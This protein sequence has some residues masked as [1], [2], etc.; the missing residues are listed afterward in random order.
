MR[1]GIAVLGLVLCVGVA[2]GQGPALDGL[3]WT[4]DGN[5]KSYPVLFALNPPPWAVKGE[6]S[7]NLQKYPKGTITSKEL[8]VEIRSM[9]TIDPGTGKLA[10][11]ATTKATVDKDGK[12]FKIESPAGGSPEDPV[13]ITVTGKFKP[14]DK[15]GE[16]D[17][18]LSGV[19]SSK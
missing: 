2:A 11:L 5:G 12:T 4:T 8:A 17:V 19:A 16:R 6:G 7:V 10:I 1:R 14:D 15:L 18:V 9:K 3:V 13:T